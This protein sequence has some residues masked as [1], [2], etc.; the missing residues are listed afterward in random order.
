MAKE[1]LEK[2]LGRLTLT[3][4]VKHTCKSQAPT[5]KAETK[6]ERGFLGGGLG[7]GGM[8]GYMLQNAVVVQA[9]QLR[10]SGLKMSATLALWL[11]VCPFVR[12]C[13]CHRLALCQ[14]SKL[15]VALQQQQQQQQK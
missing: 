9:R 5:A 15:E 3:S 13:V 11:S 7:R 1:I 2:I 10:R 4:R 14:T 12:L 6:L 8:G